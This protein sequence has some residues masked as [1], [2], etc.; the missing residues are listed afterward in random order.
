MDLM[1]K[2][3]LSS[4][5]KNR[6]TRAEEM[7]TLGK[8][9]WLP[10]PNGASVQQLESQLPSVFKINSTT[11]KLY[12]NERT[13]LE[14]TSQNNAQSK[15]LKDQMAMI[16]KVKKSDFRS[17]LSHYQQITDCSFRENAR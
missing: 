14:V 6:K 16:E 7:P 15:Y 3:Y 4:Q 1:L 2:T 8:T 17:R 13:Y 9:K 11:K 10:R 5:K 12:G